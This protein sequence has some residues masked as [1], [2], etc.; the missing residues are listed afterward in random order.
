MF[1]TKRPPPSVQTA[2]ERRQERAFRMIRAPNE[3]E[4][5]RRYDVFVGDDLAGHAQISNKPEEGEPPDTRYVTIVVVEEQFRRRGLATKLYDTIEEDL[6]SKGLRL[7]ESQ[8]QDDGGGIKEFW[9]K[10]VSSRTL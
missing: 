9:Q 3:I 1:K 6:A 2:A 8:H 7:V 4:V 5:M 10:R